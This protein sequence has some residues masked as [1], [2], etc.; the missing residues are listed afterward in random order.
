MGG[1]PDLRQLAFVQTLPE[2]IR[3]VT[4]VEMCPLLLLVAGPAKARN[5]SDAGIPRIYAWGVSKARN[6]ALLIALKFGLVILR[7]HWWLQNL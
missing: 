6:S 3:E 4:P 1:F 5:V 2:G 7:K